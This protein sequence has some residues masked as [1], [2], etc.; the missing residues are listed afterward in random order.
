M[1]ITIFTSALVNEKENNNLKI[2]IKIFDLYILSGWKVIFKI[3]I[4]LIKNNSIKIFS[5]PYEHLIHYLNNA[6]IQED[7]FKN[8]NLNE[9]INISF[10][11]KISNKLINNLCKEFEMKGKIMNKNNNNN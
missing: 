4:S 2:I 5:L 8:K 6:L 1:F 7:F 10:N 3:G 9:L 11:F